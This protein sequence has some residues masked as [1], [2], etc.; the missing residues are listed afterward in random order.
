MKYFFACPC[1]CTGDTVADGVPGDVKN[2]PFCERYLTL[3]PKVPSL[4]RPS[5]DSE[6]Q[7]DDKHRELVTDQFVAALARYRQHQH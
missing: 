6:R 4:L 7:A 5:T 1:G 2:C 3:D